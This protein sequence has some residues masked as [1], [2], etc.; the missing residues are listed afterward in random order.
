M[1]AILVPVGGTVSRPSLKN[2]NDHINYLKSKGNV[3]WNV[4]ASGAPKN[5]DIKRELPWKYD[6]I[7]KG[8]F[9]LNKTN[10]EPCRI[11]H[12]FKFEYVRQIWEL[13]SKFNTIEEYIPKWRFQFF[14]SDS[15]DYLMNDYAIL[16]NEIT[17]LPVEK[18]LDDFIVVS[19]NK[20]PAKNP[21]RYFIVEDL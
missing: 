21:Q 5:K 1:N 2:I 19:T 8:Y 14:N 11:T 20:A 9:S 3:F 15:D 13:Q 16:I 17:Q 7:K 4:S 18:R 10:N 12:E 6:Y